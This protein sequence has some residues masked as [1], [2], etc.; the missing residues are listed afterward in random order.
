MPGALKQKTLLPGSR[1]KEEIPKQPLPLI[2][3]AQSIRQGKISAEEALAP[4]AW[5]L[6]A[7][8]LKFAPAAAR[9]ALEEVVD[10]GLL[11]RVGTFY[12]VSHPL[13]HTCAQQVLLAGQEATQQAALL[14]RL[15]TVLA[16]HFPQVDH[17]N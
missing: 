8:V 13:I 16:E 10:Y 1:S 17:A 12:E 15:V 14:A 2:Q 11:V 6:V 9:R 3:L 4:F 7:D 5:E